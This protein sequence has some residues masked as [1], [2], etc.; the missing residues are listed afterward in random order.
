MKKLLVWIVWILAVLWVSSAQSLTLSTEWDGKF[1]YWCVVPVDVYANAQWLEIDS[2][3]LYITYNMEYLD[4]VPSNE[5]LWNYF[6]PNNW[7][8]WLYIWGIIWMNNYNTWSWKIWTIFFKQKSNFIAWSVEINK[9]ST[10]FW[11]RWKE[12]LNDVSNLEVAF[13]DTLDACEHDSSLSITG[14]YN[15]KDAESVKQEIINEMVVLTEGN[16]EH[17]IIRICLI[18]LSFVVLI[19]VLILIIKKY[20]LV[21]LNK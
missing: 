2:I 21:K 11:S 5:F 19:V 8:N 12:I 17:Q 14:W 3:D 13:V 15:G 7:D 18:W 6:Y 10:N 9:N 4:F 20:L 1:W 16:N